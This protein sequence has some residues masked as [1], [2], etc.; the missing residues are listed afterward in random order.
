VEPFVGSGAVFFA[1][2]PAKALLSDTNEELVATFRAVRDAPKKVIQF[3]STFD[4]SPAT[5]ARVKN[6]RPRS[7]AGRAARLIYLNKTAFNGLYRVN[8][9]GQ[10]NVPYGCKPGTIVCEVNTLKD[11][12][13][14]LS[15]ATVLR[16]DFRQ[17]LR[18]IQ[19]QQDVLYVDPPYTVKHNDNGFRR[20]NEQIFSW[21]DQ[22]ELAQRLTDLAAR[23]TRIVLSNADNN[24]VRRLYSSEHFHIME[25]PR[26]SSMAADPRMRGTFCELLI[27]S[28]PVC[29]NRHEIRK[30]LETEI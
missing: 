1:L 4:T 28:R 12:S 30:S 13:T 16:Q 9:M 15:C 2:C 10:F 6:S 27:I 21:Q 11:A 23:G 8:R 3:L 29:G 22:E 18:H 7:D 20:Y 24:A 14:A 5:F 25:L 26:R 19:P 17:T